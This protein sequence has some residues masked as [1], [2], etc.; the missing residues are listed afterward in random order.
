[1][2]ENVLRVLFLVNINSVFILH[3]PFAAHCVRY[4]QEQQQQQKKHNWLFYQ[5]R[6]RLRQNAK[7]EEFI[8]NERTGK[9][10]VRDL[11][12]TDRSNVPD[13]ELKAPIIKDTRWA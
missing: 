10:T 3:L 11:S 1:M 9:A 5:R 2:L 12:E 13:G 7:T 8:S 4:F 6:Q